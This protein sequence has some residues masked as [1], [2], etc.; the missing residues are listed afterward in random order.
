[1]F[2][3]ERAERSLVAATKGRDQLLVSSWPGAI[4]I[5]P[6]RGLLLRHRAILS[7]APRG[8]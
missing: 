3:D 5:A 4:G 1:V 2:L 6:L 8:N 7:P